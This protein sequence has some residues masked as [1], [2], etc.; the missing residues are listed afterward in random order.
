MGLLGPPNISK[1]KARGRVSKL[2]KALEHE[3]AE[4]RKEAAVALGDLKSQEAVAP[5][6]ALLDSW[7]TSVSDAASAALAQIGGVAA[8]EELGKALDASSTSTTKQLLKAIASFDGES[9]VAVLSEHLSRKI[10]I[11]SDSDQLVVDALV[12]LGHRSAIE[13]LVRLQAG[14]PPVVEECI[15]P[16]LRGV[17]YPDLDTTDRALLSIGQG[18]WEAFVSLGADAW[19]VL[20]QEGFSVYRAKA[21]RGARGK[22]AQPL[23]QILL[24]DES[25]YTRKDAAEGLRRSRWRPSNDQ[26]RISVAIAEERFEDA[27]KVGQEGT[28]RLL[29][30]LLRTHDFEVETRVKLVKALGNTGDASVVEP[31]GALARDRSVDLRVAIVK[32]LENVHTPEATRQ[33]IAMLEDQA[34]G[35]VYRKAANALGRRHWAPTDRKEQLLFSIAK[36]EPWSKIEGQDE[37]ARL[38][39]FDVH[40]TFPPTDKA[41]KPASDMSRL[42]AE[43]WAAYL[44][45]PEEAQAN[46][47]RYDGGWPTFRKKFLNE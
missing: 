3:D 13:P 28:R 44:D 19:P 2:I 5:L 24:D 17:D 4:I 6:G 8:L 43:A 22:Q 18:D 16:A 40:R 34:D 38:I 27:T 47:D 35:G 14:S 15:G 10:R 26:Q 1:L 12:A 39:W 41:T 45:L 29:D 31:L 33:L 11:W 30:L 23:L 36:G 25:E 9:A 7:S 37:E 20:Q 46:L 42:E 32:A 21:A